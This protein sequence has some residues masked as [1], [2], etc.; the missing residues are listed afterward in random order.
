MGET[1]TITKK[2]KEE[3]GKAQNPT[4]K[5]LEIKDAVPP[6]KI[7]KPRFRRKKRAY[8][9][10]FGVSVKMMPKRT[11]KPLAIYRLL[12]MGEIDPLTNQEVIA[13]PTILPSTYTLFDKF[14]ENPNRRHKVMKRTTGIRHILNPKTN[15]LEAHEDIDDVEFSG[16]YL[17]VNVA[18]QFN[19]YVFME[20]HPANDSNRFR[21]DYPNVGP[22]VFKRIDTDYKSNNE[23]VVESDLAIDAVLMIRKM[24][25]DQ[26]KEHSVAMG[27]PTTNRTADDIRWNLRNHAQNNPRKFFA[28]HPDREAKGRVLVLDALSMGLLEYDGTNRKFRLV[29]E[30]EPF[31]Q[32]AIN[33]D[34]EKD[35]I[36][37]LLSEEGKDDL[38]ELKKLVDEESGED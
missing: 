23:R 11:S 29:D 18:T 34:P 24:S 3:E 37:F 10:T 14:E 9:E 31:F 36:S 28:K 13:P 35:L 25:F 7:E 22:A 20:L 26:I 4:P 5:E 12:E 6:L 15:T 33:A 38:R 2:E 17:T 8:S 32:V 1:K 19:L 16:G 30:E 27:L 21:L